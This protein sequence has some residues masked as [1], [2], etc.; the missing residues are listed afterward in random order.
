MVV[1]RLSYTE[2]VLGSRPRVS[3]GLAPLPSGG[4]PLPLL[5]RVPRAWAA[6]GAT[7]APA[8]NRGAPARGV[9]VKPPLPAGPGEAPGA[10]NPPKTPK[11]PKK[12]ILPHFG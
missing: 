5:R 1:L 6:L 7:P 12:A 10:Q 4:D 2:L 3:R 9:D 11:S 8:G